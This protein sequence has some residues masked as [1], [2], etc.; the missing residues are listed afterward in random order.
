LDPAAAQALILDGR[1]WNNKDRYSAYDQLSDDQ[2]I[3]RLASWSPIVRERA[4]MAVGRR[5]EAPIPALLTLL[6]SPRLESRYGACQALIALHGRGAP[7]IEPLR[8]LLV[9]PDLWLRIKAAEALASIGKPAKPAVQQLLEQLAQVDTANDPRGMQQ[10]YLSFALFDDNGMLRRSL[11]GVDR[12]AL[13]KA[14]RAGLK[15]QDGRARGAI[16]SVYRNLSTEE[17]KPLLPA[18]Y[19]AVV[20][21]APSG[22][23]FADGIRVEG[24]RLL[25][26]HRIKEGISACVKYTRDQNPWASEKR[27]PELMKILLSY[28]THA[29]AVIP[30]LTR[31]GDYFAKEEKNF[32]KH[33]MQLKAKSV[34]ETI[35]AIEAS[36]DT[37]ELIRLK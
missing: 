23:M 7:A 9:E 30:E 33:L 22:E 25:A 6:E 1:G 8:K 17:I 13:Y 28:G 16:S 32:P 12:E 15:N 31:I 21:P 37:P 24:L 11:E 29:K 10:R 2:L 34:R 27:T 26:R 35:A 3:E 36:T 4:A 18:I 5:K 14:V 19:Q 20:E